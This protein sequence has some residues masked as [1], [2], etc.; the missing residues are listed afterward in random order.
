MRFYIIEETAP[1]F[2]GARKYRFKSLYNGII[3]PWEQD[4][5]VADAQG[6]SHAEL[7]QELFRVIEIC[8]SGTVASQ[9]I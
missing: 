7:I 4:R 3:G 6:V 2:Y 9:G 8:N 1:D 5:T